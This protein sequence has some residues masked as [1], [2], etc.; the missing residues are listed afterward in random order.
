MP[1]DR[2]D[3]LVRLVVRTAA[4]ISRELVSDQA[5]TR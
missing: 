5:A 3:K 1:A 4:E 2:H